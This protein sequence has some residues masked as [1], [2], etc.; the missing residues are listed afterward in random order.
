MTPDKRQE[1]RKK[2]T[3]PN[4]PAFSLG[5]AT[6]LQKSVVDQEGLNLRHAVSASM[7]FFAT[8]TETD[9]AMVVN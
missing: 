8:A 6:G 5:A 3:K 2:K 7:Q 4:T 9:W 1:I